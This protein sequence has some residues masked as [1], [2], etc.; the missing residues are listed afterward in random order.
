[1]RMRR[2]TRRQRVLTQSSS[3]VGEV[4]ECHVGTSRSW[5]HRRWVGTFRGGMAVMEVYQRYVWCTWVRRMQRILEFNGAIAKV[6][7]FGAL[8]TG[9]WGHAA[10]RGGV[11]F[12]AVQ[13]QA[14]LQGYGKAGR[15]D[16]FLDEGSRL[17]VVGS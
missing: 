13:I 1:M 14:R 6:A 8:G 17:L 15:F 10:R 9:L 16:G 4:H 7:D 2:D 3:R 5:W 11:G 12:R